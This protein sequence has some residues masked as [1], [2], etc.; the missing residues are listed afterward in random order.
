M[1]GICCI[2]QS[3]RPGGGGAD[4]ER[5]RGRGIYKYIGRELGRGSVTKYYFKW[6]SSTKAI[7]KAYFTF[8]LAS[9]PNA[10]NYLE[11]FYIAYFDKRILNKL[12]PIKELFKVA[13]YTASGVLNF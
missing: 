13:V 12:K 2:L 5:E 7:K 3:K 9:F 8:T 6:F 1:P 10:S 4:T 11:E